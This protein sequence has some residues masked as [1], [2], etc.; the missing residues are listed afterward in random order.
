MS[1]DVFNFGINIAFVGMRAQREIIRLLYDSWNIQ[2]SYENFLRIMIPCYRNLNLS[3]KSKTVTA[4]CR[5]KVTTPYAFYILNNIF[6]ILNIW[7]E[8]ISWCVLHTLSN[9][10]LYSMHRPIV[11]YIEHRVT[12]TVFKL[13]VSLI[14]NLILHLLTW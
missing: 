6:I 4:H 13:W 10:R 9:P 3:W 7:L 1:S 14:L 2:L 11:A 5:T 12:L 8:S